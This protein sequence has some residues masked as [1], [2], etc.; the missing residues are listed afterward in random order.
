MCTRLCVCHRFKARKRPQEGR[1]VEW[2]ESMDPS[3]TPN[4]KKTEKRA[5]PTKLTTSKNSVLQSIYGKT[6]GIW[7]YTLLRLVYTFL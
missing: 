5:Q 4:R 1:L 7:A 3:H 6:I 2:A